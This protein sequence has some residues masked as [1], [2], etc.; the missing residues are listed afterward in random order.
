VSSDQA[1]AIGAF[2]SGVG[3]VLSAI[4]Y[5][6]RQARQAEAECDKRIAEFN[7]ALHEGAELVRDRDPDHQ[8]G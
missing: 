3:S 5:T 6:R 2:L 1:A 8:D 7:R 4:W